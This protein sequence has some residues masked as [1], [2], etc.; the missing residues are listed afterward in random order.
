MKKLWWGLIALGLF[1]VSC[2]SYFTRK[3]C[4]K[5]NWFQHA[6]NVAMNGQR[7]EEDNRFKECEKAET[8][9]N[10]AEMDRGFKAGMENYCKP[11]TA[12]AKGADG[13]SFNY[14]FCDSNIAPRLRTRFTEGLKA[15]C[16]PEAAHTFASKGGVYKNQCPKDM[17]AAYMV[18]YRKGRAIY[19]KNQIN[20]NEAQITSL[21]GEI[22]EQQSQRGH[23]S[24]RIAALPRTAI[25]SNNKTYDPATKS[26]K[27]QTA[28]TE[29]P[30]IT[31]QRNNLERDIRAVNDGILEKQRSQ[32]TLRE[33]IH[34]YRSE[35]ESLN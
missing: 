11:E 25:V 1:T 30:A 24:A 13:G 28:V 6:Y 20:N 18:R 31:Q 3:S 17:E 12:H 16:T 27:Q 15:F 8:E 4:E 23:L 26:Y 35:L 2:S 29:D 33:Q 9:I 14:D 34:Q 10:S 5:I 7:L 22:R 19:L 32:R 21:D